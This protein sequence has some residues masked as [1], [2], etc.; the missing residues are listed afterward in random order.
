MMHAAAELLQ[1]ERDA[2][3]DL[4]WF[5]LTVRSRHEFVA[6]DELER[7]GDRNLPA[8]GHQAAA[9]ARPE[10]AGR[11]PV[12]PG[13]CFV[14]IPARPNEFLHVLKTRG[15]VSLVSLVPGHPTPVPRQEIDALRTVTA[16]GAALRRLS[17]VQA[18]HAGAHPAGAAPGRR[19]R[20]RHARIARDVLRQHRDPGQ[21]RRAQ[22]PS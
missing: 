14:H 22:D 21:E 18:G 19:G 5:A 12:F 16:S 4:C 7:K 17:G 13:Y 20:T 15:T 3:T 2:R 11:V 8:V 1:R 9:V 6:R 10:E